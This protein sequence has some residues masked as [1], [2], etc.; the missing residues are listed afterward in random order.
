MRRDGRAWSPD[1]PA[2]QPEYRRLYLQTKARLEA[3]EDTI[4]RFNDI[5]DDLRKRVTELEKRLGK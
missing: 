4:V 1:E 3:F 5:I 2:R